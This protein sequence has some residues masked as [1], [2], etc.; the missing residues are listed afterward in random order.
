M[1]PA[2]GLARSRPRAP[3]ARGCGPSGCGP[4]PRR[5]RGRGGGCA[6]ARR[7]PAARATPP[8]PRRW[9]TELSGRDAAVGLRHRTSIPRRAGVASR[10]VGLHTPPST[11]SRPSIVTGLNTHGIEHDASTACATLASGEPGAPNTTRLPLRRSTAAIRSRPSKLAPDCSTSRASPPSERLP[12]GTAASAAARATAPPGAVPASAS[13]A[14]GA[15]AVL[16]IRPTA[17]GQ[18][19][20]FV[21]AGRGARGSLRARRWPR[22]PWSPTPSRR[23]PR[24][25]SPAR[26]PAA[27]NAATIEPAEVPTK[28]SQSRKSMPVARPAP[29]SSPRI[30]ASPSVPPA[31][32]TRTSGRWVSGSGTAPAYEPTN[33]TSSPP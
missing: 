21:G 23:A 14:K 11:Y 27:R 16:P 18:R 29:S 25:P 28:Y 13:G 8:A 5:R 4:S 22:R 31:A 6:R 24:G 1:P 32:R 20:P 12:R 17:D 15:A 26:R 10:F 19:A 30:H 9:S 7:A 33:V 2:R 3:R